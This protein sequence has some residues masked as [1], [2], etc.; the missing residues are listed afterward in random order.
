MLI[1]ETPDGVSSYPLGLSIS[2]RVTDDIFIMKLDL[3][4]SISEVK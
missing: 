1:L 2:L 3:L 4:T